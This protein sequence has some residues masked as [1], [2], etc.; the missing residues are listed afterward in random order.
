M[1]SFAV[2][3]QITKAQVDAL[4][5]AEDDSA[6]S[7]ELPAAFFPALERVKV[8]QSNCSRL[9]KDADQQRAGLQMLDAMTS[10]A[11]TAH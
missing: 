8:I 6:T 11:E 7:V 2:D 3:F 5:T 4:T 9:T 1:K 10:Y